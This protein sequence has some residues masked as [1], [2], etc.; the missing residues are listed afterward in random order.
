[1]EPIMYYDS[2]LPQISPPAHGRTL[3]PLRMRDSSV[4]AR[5]RK[6]LEMGC[7]QN[8]TMGKARDERSESLNV[9]AGGI[10]HDLNNL[11]TG[12]LTN[13]CMEKMSCHPE[14]DI[15]QTLSFMEMALLRAR[16]LTQQLLSFATGEAPASK[17]PWSPLG[18][19]KETSEFFLRGSRATCEHS[20]PGNLWL[21]EAPEEQVGQIIQNLIINAD[22]AMP[23]GGTIRVR[24]ENLTMAE[25]AHANLKGGKYVRISIQD[26]GRG[27]SQEQLSRIF[28]P[29]FTTKDKGMGLGLAT[30]LSLATLNHG[31]IQVASGQGR[32]TTFQVYLPAC[33]G[34]SPPEKSGETEIHKGQ[35]RILLIDDDRVIRKS[36]GD[37]IMMLGY[38]V[39][40]AKDGAQGIA[41]YKQ[42]RAAAQPFQAVI[43]DLSMP[44]GMGGRTAVRQLLKY[45]PAAKVILSS[46]FS[47]T[48]GSSY[49]EEYGFSGVLS[50]P[51]DL[52]DLGKV[53]RQLIAE[54]EG[55]RI[56][57]A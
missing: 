57:Q 23:D 5:K 30:C 46:G 8:N 20:L 12:I 22:Q 53:L 32:G 25:D 31:H 26:Q 16:G 54:P 14:H 49:L 13:V 44:G 1:M 2:E 28:E 36:V 35:G 55:S 4:S 34:L 18:L 24:A 42:A 51:Y 9:I 50:K 41:L 38:D 11:L 29:F 40:S 45:D 6:V 43:M 21:V 39:V 3:P 33:E 17:P 15:S 27:L 19:I 56:S 47:E 37:A 7:R 52:E 48:S 10:A